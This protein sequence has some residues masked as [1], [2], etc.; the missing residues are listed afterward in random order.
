MNKI[1]A[2]TIS[3]S[4]DSKSSKYIQFHKHTSY[5]TENYKECVF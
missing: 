2:L 1:K 4:V 3:E 5:Y